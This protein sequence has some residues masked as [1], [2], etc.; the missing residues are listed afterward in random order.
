MVLFFSEKIYLID[1]EVFCYPDGFFISD[2][3]RAKVVDDIECFEIDIFRRDN[4]FYLNRFFRKVRMSILFS[5][6][7][8]YVKTKCIVFFCFDRKSCSLP[9][10][11]IPY[12]KMLTL[13]KKF[14]EITPFG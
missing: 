10:S 1:S 12:K 11:T 3:K 13:I 14:D 8:C 2:S 7:F 4:T 6:L 5:K 9:V